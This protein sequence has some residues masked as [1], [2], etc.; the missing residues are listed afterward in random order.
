MFQGFY[1]SGNLS[2]GTDAA[3]SNVKGLVIQ[4]CN[5]SDIILAVNDNFNSLAENIMI[6]ESVIRANLNVRYAKDVLIENNLINGA[7]YNSNG[8]V[9]VSNNIMFGNGHSLY[10]VTSVLFE[11]NIFYQVGNFQ[12]GSGSNTF[13]NNVFRS[14]NPLN[15][16]DVSEQ[17]LFSVTNLFIQPATEFDYAI[18]FHLAAGSPAIGAGKGGTQCGI[19][20]GSRSYKEAAVPANPH[21]RSKIIADNTNAAG[22]VQVQVTVVAQQQ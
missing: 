10:I 18:N 4:R 13:R 2:L 7:F 21:I 17:N 9:K 8:S 22:Q 16:S 19:Y 6:R 12:Y 3:S 14:A 20:G 1:L 15:G 5:I 11:N